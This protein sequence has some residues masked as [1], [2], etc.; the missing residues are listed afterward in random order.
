MTPRVFLSSLCHTRLTRENMTGNSCVPCSQGAE[1]IKW[2]ASH[3]GGFLCVNVCARTK[4]REGSGRGLRTPCKANEKDSCFVFFV[5]LTH[6]PGQ[7]IQS[8]LQ[9]TTLKAW[10]V[11]PVERRRHQ[12][13]ANT[14]SCRLFAKHFVI[15]KHS[16]QEGKD[17]FSWF[18]SC[19]VAKFYLPL[20]CK[21]VMSTGDTSSLI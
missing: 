4:W 13:T 1:T 18:V 14:A 16:A 15:V 10:V 12:D 20:N 6:K 17:I 5:G 11:S 9:R 21:P 2:L 3:Q 7:P 19:W 8:R